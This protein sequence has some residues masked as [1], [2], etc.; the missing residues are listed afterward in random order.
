MEFAEERFAFIT[1]FDAR[2]GKSRSIHIIPTEYSES[3]KFLA[4]IHR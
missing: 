2:S 3:Q 4:T 1:S